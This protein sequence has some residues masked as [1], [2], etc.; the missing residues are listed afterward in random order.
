MK[1]IIGTLS[2]IILLT[3]ACAKN[4]NQLAS[5]NPAPVDAVPVP[6]KLSSDALL[7][8]YRVEHF[9][10]KTIDGDFKV[11]FPGLVET[12]EIVKENGALVIKQKSSLNGC[13]REIVSPLNVSI[14]TGIY[15]RG[16]FTRETCSGTCPVKV[17]GY[18]EGHPEQDPSFNL[19]C[20]QNNDKEESGKISLDSSHLQFEVTD[21][22]TL[23]ET[24]IRT[25]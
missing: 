15:V 19:T 22:W 21:G 11:V 13:T 18:F 1:K 10:A 5:S 2:V 23:V 24:S 25:N 4:S 6:A 20:G 14:E 9:T 7:G 3:S 16:Q 17:T 8:S 12:R